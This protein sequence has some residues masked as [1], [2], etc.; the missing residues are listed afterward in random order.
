MWGAKGD[1]N[2][3]TTEIIRAF[4][5]PVE[6]LIDAVSGAIGKVYEPRYIRKRADAKAYEIQVISETVRNNSDVPITYDSQEVSV[7]TG[8]YEEIAKRASR[9]LTYQEIAK[10][11]NIESVIDNA[12]E[13]LEKVDAVSNEPVNP[14]WMIRFFNSVEDIGDKELQKIW[15]RILA[16]EIKTPNSYSY[17]T[18]EK[19]RNMTRQEV[20]HFQLVSSLALQ[21]E[22]EKFILGD[23]KL[24]N[25]YDFKVPYLLELEE[26]GLMCAQELTLSC[27]VSDEHVDYIY[28]SQIVG[29]I[30]G[31]EK[32]TKKLNLSIHVFTGS[33]R[34]LLK[35]INSEE[36]SDYILDCLKLISRK[37]QDFVVTAHRINFI[38]DE[39]KIDY[40]KINILA[41]N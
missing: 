35:V 7:R 22:E 5:S 11:Q 32:E 41:S 15:G 31:K 26:C 40:D 13:E 37:R 2:M 12:Y 17:R 24:M 4:A 21:N 9:R 28:N 39:N 14:D 3:E 19:L 27:E 6:K 29:L 10:Q 20:E 16:G 30:K 18:L 34:Q 8:N 36:N 1:I 33:G 25:K 23:D 38:G